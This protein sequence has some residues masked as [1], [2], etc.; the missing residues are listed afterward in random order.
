MV[1]HA[2]QFERHKDD[3]EKHESSAE[4]LREKV[5]LSPEVTAE[6][7][8]TSLDIE[9]IRDQVEKQEAKTKTHIK[10]AEKEEQKPLP[11]PNAE[12]KKITLNNTLYRIRR[13]LPA[14]QRAFS[15]IIHQPTID[16]VS[17][18][19]GKTIARP[20]GFMFGAFFGLVG[21][22]TLLYLAR[23]YDFK[24]NYTSFVVFFVGGFFLGLCIEA[25]YRMF[26]PSRSRH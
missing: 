3:H 18:I 5:E 2:P 19:S 10:E 26:R 6:K 16:K 23:H 15:K 7:K 20:M 24:Y 1:E 4:K 25:I 13:E 8:E 11:P 14:R 9:K 17:E 22:T 21:S 12:L